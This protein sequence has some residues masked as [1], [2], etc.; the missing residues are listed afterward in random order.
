MRT[1]FDMV[2]RQRVVWSCA[3]IVGLFLVL[4]GH[5][6]VIPVVAG[7]ALAVAISTLRSASGSHP[8]PAPLRGGR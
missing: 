3:L 4:I 7:C 2:K 5:V 6:P 1:I 8:R